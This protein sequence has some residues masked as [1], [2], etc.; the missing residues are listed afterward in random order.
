RVQL[1][2]GLEGHVLR[3]VKFYLRALGSLLAA[4]PT[5]LAEPAIL[6]LIRRVHEGACGEQIEEIAQNVCRLRLGGRRADLALAAATSGGEVVRADHTGLP[7]G[8]AQQLHGGQ[9]VQGVLELPPAREG[10]V[11][12]TRQE[13][14]SGLVVHSLV[15]AI[16]QLVEPVD[17]ATQLET[18]SVAEVDGHRLAPAE[19]LALRRATE[20]DLEAEGPA[21]VGVLGLELEEEDEVVQQLALFALID[22][23]RWRRYQRAM[24][25]QRCQTELAHPCP[26][27]RRVR[28]L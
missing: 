8:L 23:L 10:G 1:P 3:P 2:V 26:V 4:C 6:V 27:A 20:R 25:G 13:R 24:L 12:T 5:K 7:V 28:R 14:T 21:P 9:C 19:R 16:G 17:A 15:G 18:K 11:E 22:T